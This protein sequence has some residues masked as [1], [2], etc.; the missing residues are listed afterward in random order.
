MGTPRHESKISFQ[1]HP[2]GV[3]GV[4][5]EKNV[6]SFIERFGFPVTA[7]N[8]V[9]GQ[10]FD[11]EWKP[12]KP[13]H[14]AEIF[15]AEPLTAQ[16]Q[17]RLSQWL[18]H[19]IQMW[20]D[21]ENMRFISQELPILDKGDFDQHTERLCRRIMW[22][23]GHDV[24]MTSALG[25]QGKI[26][27]IQLAPLGFWRKMAN[28]AWSLDLLLPTA[29]AKLQQRVLEFSRP[30]DTYGRIVRVWLRKLHQHNFFDEVHGWVKAHY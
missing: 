23:L 8:V 16:E 30:M 15:I 4:D 28:K 21:A 17:Y 3:D 20:I 10:S 6:I 13:A 11:I 27:K 18:G 26:L 14:S 7:I 19:T 9:S 24:E 1:G 12:K 2:L 29:D 22:A 25:G 5:V